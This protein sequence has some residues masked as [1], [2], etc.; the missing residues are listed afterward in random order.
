MSWSL[1]LSAYVVLVAIVAVL[2]ARVLLRAADYEFDA[3]ELRPLF[4]QPDGAFLHQ[5]ILSY[6]GDRPDIYYVVAGNADS[7]IAIARLLSV[8]DHSA[9][10]MGVSTEIR[11]VD[12]QRLPCISAIDLTIDDE[13]ELA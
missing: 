12:C 10:N 11:T 3:E 2:A 9:A 5:V 1:A 8:N 4:F 6:R 7:A 13:R